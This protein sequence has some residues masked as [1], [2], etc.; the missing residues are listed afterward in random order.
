MKKIMVNIDNIKWKTDGVSEE[1]LKHLPQL[2][3]R[4]EFKL[5]DDEKIEDLIPDWLT[6]TWC[7]D[8]DGF[9]LEVISERHSPFLEDIL[10]EIVVDEEDPDFEKMESDIASQMPGYE[11][12][13]VDMDDFNSSMETAW[14]TADA[15]GRYADKGIEDIISHSWYSSDDEIAVLVIAIKTKGVQNV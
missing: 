10:E 2:I 9:D 1:T 11:I 13:L 4:R 6:D 7:C 5:E 8:H 15:I 3:A 12:E 14:A